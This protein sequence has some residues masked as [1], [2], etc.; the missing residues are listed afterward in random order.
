M[1]VGRAHIQTLLKSS[2]YRKQ[3]S[4]AWFKQRGG[5]GALGTAR[6]LELDNLGLVQSLLGWGQV[7]ALETICQVCQGFPAHMSRVPSMSTFSTCHMLKHGLSHTN[8]FLHEQN[9]KEFV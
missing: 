8:S 3:L 4:G 5:L 9:S 1:T 7:A 2:Q 6:A